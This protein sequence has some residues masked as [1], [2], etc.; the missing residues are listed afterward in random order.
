[1]SEQISNR[2]R[3][4][5]EIRLL[6]HYWLDEGTTVFDLLKSK[7]DSEDKNKEK[8]NERLRSYDFRRFFVIEPTAGTA[9]ALSGLGCVYKTTS[10]GCV[11][12][13]P[14][15]V[16]IPIETMFEFVVTVR[17]PDLFNYT[18]LTLRPQ[19]IYEMYYQPEK[20]TYRYKVNVPVLSNLTGAV[21]DIGPEDNT[22]KTLF[23]SKEFP[24]P[25]PE[26]DQVESL[27][28]QDN[29]LK[30]RTGEQQNA[31]SVALYNST[32]ADELPI[33]VH[34]DDIPVIVPPEGLAGVPARG[35]LLSDDIPDNIFAFIRLTATREEDEDFSLVDENG[36]A[37]ENYPVF[38]IRFKNRS[39]YWQY[40]NKK[41]GEVISDEAETEPFPL[42]YFGNAGTG[43]KPSKELLIKAEKSNSGKIIKLTSEIFI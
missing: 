32:P 37:K 23:L 13:V 24:M 15:S 34:Q 5:F 30:Q 29:A 12:A 26:D 22:V 19:K 2:Y 4:L 31:A 3:P 38:H 17:D 25:A 10:L 41:T 6:H 42:T 14:E 27:F 9:K 18:A 20:K 1:M 21:R 43:Q 11:V 39:T 7:E 40:H 33:F 36:Q 8:R 35:L 28:I 16:I